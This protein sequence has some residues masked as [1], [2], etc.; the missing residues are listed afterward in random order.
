MS[1]F[2]R[3]RTWVLQSIKLITATIF[4]AYTIRRL[5]FRQ[6][7]V[8]FK[9]NQ[10]GN[11]INWLALHL[12]ALHLLALHLLALYLLALHLLA[13]HLVALHLIVLHLI[14]L[15]L[16]ALH[17]VAL[18][19]LALQLTNWLTIQIM[20]NVLWLYSILHVH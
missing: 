19:L 9:L 11:N 17:L 1:D 15:H 6:I 4:K 7:S 13:L 8:R 12:I 3:D 16:P 2:Q 20:G 10:F 5:H 18:H 14:A